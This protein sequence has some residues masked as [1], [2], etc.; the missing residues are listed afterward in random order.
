MEVADKTPQTFGSCPGA[1]HMTT[2][3]RIVM[4][5]NVSDSLS[6]DQEGVDQFLSIAMSRMFLEYMQGA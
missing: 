3:P 6:I 5:F 1:W 4:M 2:E